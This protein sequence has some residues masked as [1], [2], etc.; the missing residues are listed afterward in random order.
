VPR[1]AAGR[2][3]VYVINDGAVLGKGTP[4]NLVVR[5]SVLKQFVNALP[6]ARCASIS[7]GRRWR[8]TAA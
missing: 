4:R 3:Y 5:E 1:G 8:R 6:E 2:D 7:R